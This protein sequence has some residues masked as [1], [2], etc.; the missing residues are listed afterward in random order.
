MIII[1]GGLYW[2]SPILGKYHV[3]IRKLRYVYIRKLAAD[4][5]LQGTGFQVEVGLQEQNAFLHLGFLQEWTRFLR[6]KMAT[7]MRSSLRTL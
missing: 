7:L 1:F 4:A 3:Y 5:G 6:L 2:G